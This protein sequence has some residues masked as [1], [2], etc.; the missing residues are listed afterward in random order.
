MTR[1]GGSRSWE[2]WRSAGC[3]RLRPAPKSTNLGKS[4]AVAWLVD[5]QTQ[6]VESGESQGMIGR[7]I[8]LRVWYVQTAAQRDPPQRDISTGLFSTITLSI[9]AGFI[10]LDAGC[11]TVS[12]GFFPNDSALLK[13]RGFSGDRAV[14]AVRLC[15]IL[16][17][18]GLLHR[19]RALFYFTNSPCT[20]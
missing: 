18:D 4:H 8:H 20:V 3:I 11:T 9:P 1:S 2:S 16:S 13:I 19:H 14:S 15:L 7:G 5:R 6:P 10:T 12:G 17:T